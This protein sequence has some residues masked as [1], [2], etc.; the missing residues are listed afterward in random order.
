MFHSSEHGEVEYLQLVQRKSTAG[1]S[2]WMHI[3]HYETAK[4]MR[5]PL[6]VPFHSAKSPQASKT[7][8]TH[9]SLAG[10][11]FSVIWGQGTEPHP[12]L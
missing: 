8:R 4:G 3:T 2:T 9:I 6:A 5:S 7:S 11:L 1:P 12:V 10:E